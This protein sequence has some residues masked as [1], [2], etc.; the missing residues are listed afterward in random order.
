MTMND[1][2]PD[3]GSPPGA[4]I[5]EYQQIRGLSTAAL[6]RELDLSVAQTR[7]LLDGTLHITPHLALALE[8]AL[9]TPAS[10]WARREYL[11]R[12]SLHNR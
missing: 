8:A 11:Y 10:F 9:D 1:Y 5:R 7:A 6:A 3:V 2:H 4:T 12:Q